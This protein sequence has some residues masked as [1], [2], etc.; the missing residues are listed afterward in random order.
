MEL[1]EKRQI[2]IDEAVEEM[3]STI[4]E[5]TVKCGKCEY[6]KD[7]SCLNPIDLGCDINEDILN[8]CDALY[9]AGYRKIADDHA[10]QCTCYALGCQMAESLK[11]NAAKGIFADINNSLNK[12]QHLINE[13]IAKSV[14]EQDEESKKAYGN[15]SAVVDAIRTCIYYIVEKYEGNTGEWKSPVW[16]GEMWKEYREKYTEETK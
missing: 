13:G 3:A 11:K 15:A 10:R 9:N 5:I 8:E 14:W 16:T 2:Y 4:R 12:I 6:Y 7:G 1:N